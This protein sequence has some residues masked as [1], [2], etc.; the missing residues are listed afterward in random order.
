MDL[1]VLSLWECLFQNFRQ[2]IDKNISSVGTVNTDL[3]I[4]LAVFIK[5]NP[6]G[7]FGNDGVYQSDIFVEVK[8]DSAVF[9]LQPGIGDP[10]VNPLPQGLLTEEFWLKDT[11]CRVQGLNFFQQFTTFNCRKVRFLIGI[12]NTVQNAG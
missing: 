9:L 1:F 11:N 3:R 7:I 8:G 6:D 2:R 4:Q 5:S 10:G 12:V